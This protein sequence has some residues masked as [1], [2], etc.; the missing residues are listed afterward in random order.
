MV[1]GCNLAVGR[2]EK[3]GKDTRQQAAHIHVFKEGSLSEGKER[4]L[5]IH[6]FFFTVL[7]V[8]DF[9]FSFSTVLVPL[10]Y[11]SP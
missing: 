1:G 9:L 4:F 2:I 10:I 7:F 8:S 11:C 5:A 6:L 3:E